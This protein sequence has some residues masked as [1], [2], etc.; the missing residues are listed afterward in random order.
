MPYVS[1]KTGTVTP[2]A[3]RDPRFVESGRRGARKR[4]GEPRVA[5][6]DSLSGPMRAIVL[7]LIAAAKTE[8]AASEVPAS[9]SAEVC[10]EHPTRAA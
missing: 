7:A 1:R 3:E 9:S 5:R 10:R 6:L 8:P 2:P 4:Y